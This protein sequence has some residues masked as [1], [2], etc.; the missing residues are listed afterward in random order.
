[1]V[2]LVTCSL[3]TFLLVLAFTQI[4]YW[5]TQKITWKT[6]RK[7]TFFPPKSQLGNGQSPSEYAKKV[8][9]HCLQWL[10]QVE[11]PQTLLLCGKKIYFILKCGMKNAGKEQEHPSSPRALGRPACAGQRPRRR[12]ATRQGGSGTYGEEVTAGRADNWLG[13]HDGPGRGEGGRSGLDGGHSS[14]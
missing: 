6:H 2:N 1:M 5:L 7:I 3:G 9:D 10:K 8:F 14:T 13:G 4:R 12:S 11:F